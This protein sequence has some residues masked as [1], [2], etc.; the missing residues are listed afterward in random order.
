[1]TKYIEAAIM[2]EP[3]TSINNGHVI[4]SGFNKELDDLRNIKNNI[5]ELI[6]NLISREKKRLG[7]SNVK[8][9]YNKIH[10]FYLELPRSVSLDL[11]EVYSARQTKIHKDIFFLN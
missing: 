4:Q 6:S 2:N 8:I 9:E 3:A 5:D 11:T 10:G 7:Y 1:M